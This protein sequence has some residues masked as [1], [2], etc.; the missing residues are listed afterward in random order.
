MGQTRTASQLPFLL[1][2]AVTGV[3]E[4]VTVKAEEE[5]K[6]EVEAIADFGAIWFKWPGEERGL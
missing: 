6:E 1:E 3:G 2:D 4:E 5:E